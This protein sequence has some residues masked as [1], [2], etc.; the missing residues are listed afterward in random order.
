MGFQMARGKDVRAKVLAAA[1]ELFASQGYET[2]SVQQVV[3]R[4]GVTKG[5]LY[6]YFPTKEALLIEMYRSVFA[7]RQAALDAIIA[8]ELEPATTLRA[9]IDDLVVGTLAMAHAP[10][11]INRELSRVDAERI[12]PL[13][14]DW[15][16][17]QDTVRKVIRD[18]QVAGVFRGRTSPEVASWAIFGVTNTIHTWYRATGPKSPHD[19]AAELADLIIGGLAN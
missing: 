12:A 5:A 1:A 3:D 11:A 18:A 17:Y 10:A 14:A 7:Q 9:I 8:R 13:R 16:R 2:T 6:H 15:Q 19:I 4:A